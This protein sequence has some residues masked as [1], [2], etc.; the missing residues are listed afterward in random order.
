MRFEIRQS[1]RVLLLLLD[2]LLLVIFSKL[3]LGAWFPPV[4]NEGFLVLCLLF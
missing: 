2:I 3:A 1:T 4:G